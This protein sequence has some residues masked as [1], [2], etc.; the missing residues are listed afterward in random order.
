M[1][2]SEI[3]KR[4]RDEA[5]SE[6]EAINKEVQ[7]KVDEIKQDIKAEAK[8]KADKIRKDG[9]SEAALEYRRMI[10]D[11]V[12]ESSDLLEKEKNLLMR[13]VFEEARQKIESLPDAEKKKILERL[14]ADGKKSIK[15][16]QVLVDKKYAKL[17]SGA[18]ASDIGDFG[19]IL[20]SKDGKMRIDNTLGTRL[21][22]IEKSM[23]SDVALRL[24]K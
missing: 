14:A 13:K 19:A 7:A 20:E 22:Q 12:I 6:I 21:G 24:F 9:A 17:I 2:L 10:A 8:K 16:P 1:G 18:K 3:E 23:R 11:A 15:D 5:A 4:I